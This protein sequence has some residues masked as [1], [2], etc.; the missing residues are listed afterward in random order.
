MSDIL[1]AGLLVSGLL[2][3]A[4][5]TLAR[6]CYSRRAYRSGNLIHYHPDGPE[7]ETVTCDRL[8]GGPARIGYVPG[9]PE[10]ERITIMPRDVTKRETLDFA[11]PLTLSA[12]PA[13]LNRDDFRGPAHPNLY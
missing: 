6:Y 7:W 9:L 8:D 13:K 5:I 2:V 3:S 12:A 4:G 10:A 11:P 1:A